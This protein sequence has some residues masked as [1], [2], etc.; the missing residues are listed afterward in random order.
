M[1]SLFYAS[2]KWIKRTKTISNL[3]DSCQKKIKKNIV[4][5][6]LSLYAYLI[7]EIYYFPCLF[8]LRWRDGFCSHHYL[9]LWLSS[10]LNMCCTRL[11]HELSVRSQSF[12]RTW[13]VRAIIL[14][15][16]LRA[17]KINDFPLS[18]LSRYN[19]TNSVGNIFRYSIRI[20]VKFL[21]FY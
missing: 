17:R 9:Y 7:I 21:W 3:T 14:S 4:L 6:F 2:K 20:L 8:N 15:S 11:I 16:S 5:V 13:R 12:L 19:N 18:V 1:Q 10:H